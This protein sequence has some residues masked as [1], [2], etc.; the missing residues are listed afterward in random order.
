MKTLFYKLFALSFRLCA[1]APMKPRRVVLLSPHNAD[2]NDSLGRVGRE[3]EKR[4][5]FDIVR[6]SRRDIE[7]VKQKTFTQKIAAPFKALRFFTVGAYRLATARYVFLNDNF[8]P[9]ADLRFRPEAVITQLWHAEGVFKRFGLTMRNTNPEVR[10]REAGGNERLSYVVCSSP[11]IAP[12]YAEAFGVPPA[13]VLPLGSPRTDVFF[14]PFDLA[15]VRAAFNKEHPECAGKDLILYAPTFRDDPEKDKELLRHFDFDA[16]A[17]AFGGRYALLVRLHPQIRADAVRSRAVTDVT[18]HPDVGVLIQ[19]ST[20]LITDYSSV[21]MDFALLNK[22]CVFYAYDLEEYTRERDFFF[23]YKNYVPG[24]V[25]VTFEQLLE[26]VAA[27]GRDE[28]KLARFRAF[29]FGS[30]DGRAAERVVDA[31]LNNQPPKYS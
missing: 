30:P 9:M 6:L 3:F 10:R 26:A 25:A 4:G 12:L 22:P 13:R 19:L 16:F 27:G 29:N 31:V 15:A 11:D 18:A 24:P 7:G 5:G 28:D 23:E 20:M 8:M 1:K 14:E 17:R 21:C 2:F